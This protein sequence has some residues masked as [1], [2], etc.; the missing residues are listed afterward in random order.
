MG[1]KVF[2]DLTISMRNFGR[3]EDADGN[4]WETLPTLFRKYVADL[5][6]VEGEDTKIIIQINGGGV[7]RF[8]PHDE[9]DVDT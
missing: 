9:A 8:M 4:R 3:A 7:R 6:P 5:K 1:M 2:T